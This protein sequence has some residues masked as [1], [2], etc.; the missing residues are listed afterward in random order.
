MIETVQVLGL[1]DLV[2]FVREISREPENLAVTIVLLR[3]AAKVAPD[4]HTAAKV[5][6]R[7]SRP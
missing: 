5:S 2:K 6:T 7:T 1:H 4:L 3:T